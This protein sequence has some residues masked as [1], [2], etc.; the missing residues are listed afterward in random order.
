MSAD[1]LK[2]EL[3]HIEIFGKPALRS[4]SRIDQKAHWFAGTALNC[5]DQAMASVLS[6]LNTILDNEMEQLLCFD[7]AIDAEKFC[8]TKSVIFIMLP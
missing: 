7:T 3:E 1:F 4:D 5:A 6:R 8:N 2:E